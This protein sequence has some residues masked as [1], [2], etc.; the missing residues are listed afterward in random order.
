MQAKLVFLFTAI[1][2]LFFG[3]SLLLLPEFI[4]GLLEATYLPV[5]PVL[6]QHTGAWVLAASVMALLI[7]DEE[8]SNFRQS[9]FIFFTLAFGL[10]TAVEVYAYL[11]ALVGIMAVALAGL[12]GFF[13]ILY[14][15]L[16]VTNR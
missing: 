16:F 14:V 3:I 2:G 8:H 6:A 5:A 1:V 9:V 10:M 13:V 7:R 4:I 15:Y 11:M 12:H